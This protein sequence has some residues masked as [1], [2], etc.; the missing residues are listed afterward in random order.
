MRVK[1]PALEVG[2]E[3]AFDPELHPADSGRDH[4]LFGLVDQKSCGNRRK[5]WKMK[6]CWQTHR[7]DEGE[8]C[9]INCG[10]SKKQ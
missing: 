7:F 2:E 5:K 9:G 8:A 3:I 10:Y 4:V 6:K 1:L